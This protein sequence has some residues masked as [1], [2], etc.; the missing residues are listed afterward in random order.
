MALRAI[1]LS[2][3]LLCC[4]FPGLLVVTAT[5]RVGATDATPV[6]SPYTPAHTA[7]L[8]PSE[9]LV[10]VM[11]GHQ[12]FRV[13]FNGIKQDRVPAFLYIPKQRTGKCPAVLLQY[14][15]GGNKGSGYIVQIG[16]YFAD[17]G[18][19]VL[20][21]DSPGKGERAPKVRH[22][23]DALN[24]KRG[25]DLFI[26]YLGDY[27]RAI[28]YLATRPEVDTKRIGYVGI[29]WGAITGI[30]FVAHDSRIRATASLVGGGDVV[31]HLPIKLADD[32]KKELERLDPVNHI[33]LIAPRPL[34]LINVTH[35]QLIPRACA[36]ALHH[37]AGK[38]AK[39]VWLDTDHYFHNLDRMK[40]AQSVVDFLRQ[41]MAAGAE[42]R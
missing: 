20:T 22:W 5:G 1:R 38:G 12:Q 32:F 27:S 16:R 28:D 9:R 17:R 19:V 34:L 35:D 40:V 33:A 8:K 21:I 7:P 30:T 6:V 24:L 11:P 10:R 26:Q 14:G 31:H 2:Y 4:I 23:Y 42:T 41:N 18:F 36:E 15:S 13:E 3:V 25:H 37:A 29:S 39:I